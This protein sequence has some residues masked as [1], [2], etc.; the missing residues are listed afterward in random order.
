M[1]EEIEMNCVPNI[2]SQ[3]DGNANFGNICLLEDEINV[4]NL[5]E[6]CVA[7]ILSTSETLGHQ[8]TRTIAENWNTDDLLYTFGSN[9]PTALTLFSYGEAMTSFFDV[10]T[11]T[12]IDLATIDLIR[13]RERGVSRYN[14]FREQLGM[15]RIASY[16]I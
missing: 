6:D 11:G 13:Q 1:P 2:A 14:D 4:N 9:S 12:V 10:E 3:I 5:N 15:T 7:E 16:K 8:A